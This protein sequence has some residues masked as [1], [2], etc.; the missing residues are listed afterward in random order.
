M[1]DEITY[2]FSNINGCTTEAWEMISNF[3]PHFTG[4][5]ITYPCQHSSESMS[6]KGA[7]GVAMYFS[8]QN[9]IYMAMHQGR[10]HLKCWNAP[11][12]KTDQPSVFM[13]I[14][15]LY[16]L[17]APRS[18]TSHWLMFFVVNATGNKAYLIYLFVG[19]GMNEHLVRKYCLENNIKFHS[20]FQCKNKSYLSW[21]HFFICS[22]VFSGIW[23]KA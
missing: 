20:I 1:W 16:I 15:A 12:A 17:F 14:S 4:H 3:I 2:S 6:V 11:D 10:S 8:K 9:L 23:E 7:P 19:R 18:Y 22:E 13:Y 5:V 21:N